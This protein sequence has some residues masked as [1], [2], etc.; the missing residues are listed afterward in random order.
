MALTTEQQQ[1]ITEITKEDVKLVKVE[2]CAGSGKTHTLVEVAN[3]LNPSSGIYLA[4][5]KAIAEEAGKKFTGTAVKCST[6]HSLAYRAIVRQWGLQVGW[7]NPRDVVADDLDYKGK[8]QVVSVLDKFLNSNSVD[9]KG[10]CETNKISEATKYYVMEHLD[11]MANGVI[12]SPHSFYL[13]MYHILLVTEGIPA[14]ETDL[15]LLDEAGD[16]NAV[17]L[18]IFTHI[19]AKKKVM[20]GDA[21][22]N[23]YQFNHTING[24]QVLKDEGVTVKLTRSFRVSDVIASRIEKFMQT[25]IDTSFDFKG[26]SYP[27]DHVPVTKGYISRN[28]T[29]LVEEML[30]LQE[31]NICFHTTRKAELIIELPLV[32]ANLG[33]GKKIEN[34]KFKHIEALRASWEKQSKDPVF[35]TQYST[36]LKYAKS[37]LQEDDEFNYGVD[38][39]TKYTPRKINSLIKY[40]AECAKKPSTL[41]LSTGHSSK[42]LEFDAVEIAPDFNVA[43][44]KAK[45]NLKEATKTNNIKAIEAASSE[46]LLYYVAC[47]RAMV[48]LIN[49]K[50]L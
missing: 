6:L 7:F 1:V 19:K 43:L 48:E 8:K 20:V 23:I 11:M 28:N 26:R 32:L 41:I 50:H 33:N 5:N 35:T 15:L 16:V 17:T 36:P 21:S 31:D 27:V 47:S 9:A 29:G 44:T 30:R 37:K 25:N 2:A 46:F 24:F 39:L 45:K 18:D 3:V 10:Y 34:S 22:Q 40:A 13:K 38:L 49:A 12:A 42:G 4:Y 14:P